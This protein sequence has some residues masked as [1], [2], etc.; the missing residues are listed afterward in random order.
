MFEGI[1]EVLGNARGVNL[2]E[3][4]QR[5]GKGNAWFCL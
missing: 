4:M 5:T 3:R 1:I 2:Q